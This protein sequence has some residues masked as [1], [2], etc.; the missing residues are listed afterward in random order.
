M[1][2][3]SA[4]L[5]PFYLALRSTLVIAVCGRRGISAALVLKI[6]LAVSNSGC[7]QGASYLHRICAYCESKTLAK[8]KPPPAAPFATR[9]GDSLLLRQFRGEA[10]VLD[11]ILSLEKKVF[12]KKSSWTGQT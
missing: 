11:Q 8:S 5:V 12:A 4:P 1:L 10:S 3:T 6:G 2:L 7:T 9:C